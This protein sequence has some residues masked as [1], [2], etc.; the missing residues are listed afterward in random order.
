MKSLDIFDRRLIA[1]GRAMSSPFVD[2]VMHRIEINSQLVRT[3]NEAPKRSR[4]ELFMMKL[5]TLPIAALI[6]IAIA[7]A[8]SLGGISYATVNLI[9]THP[10]Q[11]ELKKSS[12]D[13]NGR[14]AIS[15]AM[16]N[17]VGG[18]Y[19]NGQTDSNQY[20]ITPGSGVSAGD[21]TKLIQA[22]CE[23]GQI[24]SL[25]PNNLHG[26]VAMAPIGTVASLSDTAIGLTTVDGETTTFQL[27]KM[28]KYYAAGVASSHKDL[29]V[30]DTVMLVPADVDYELTHQTTIAD[31]V[32]KLALPAQW[33]SDDRQQYVRVLNPCDGN[34]NMLCLQESNIN[35]VSLQVSSG[36]STAGAE[37]PG[38]TD[39][40]MQGKLIAHTASS[41]TLENNGHTVTFQTPYDVIARYNTI[42][43]YGLAA[44]DQIYAKTS[45]DALKI[46]TGDTLS[47]GYTTTNSRQTTIPWQNL[48]GIDL[49]VERV[50]NNVS[51]LRKYE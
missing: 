16:R 19:T 29:V 9:R 40:M 22:R 17:C 31:V 32:A 24:Q 14:T 34:A 45:P 15:L 41:F 18:Q 48:S 35:A 30:G 39:H 20:E 12:R 1:A 8:L 11:P 46:T 10:W 26:N 42:T 6:A 2:T 4:K 28:T 47:V 50:P 5:R 21:A 36:G 44:Y 33:Y 38:T 3:K 49:V 27:S 7:A 43:V 51:V 13:T 23:I 37:L 25:V